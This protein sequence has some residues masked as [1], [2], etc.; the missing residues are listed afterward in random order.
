V[1]SVAYRSHPPLPGWI[2]ATLSLV[3]GWFVSAVAIL[4]IYIA[5]TL[6]GAISQPYAAW[7][8]G[9][10]NEWPYADNGP[11]SF[12]ANVAVVLIALV[13]ATVATSWRLRRKHA[14]VSDG[15]LAVVLLFA[16]WIPL[17]AA[18][19]TGGLVGFLVAL[20]LVRHWVARHEDHLAPKY[21]AVLVAVLGIVVVSYGLLHPLW[22]ASVDQNISFGKQRLAGIN[23]HNAA[24]VGVTIDRIEVPGGSGFPYGRPRPARLHLGPGDDGTIGLPIAPAVGGC[25]TDVLGIHAHYHVFGLALSETLPARIRLGRSC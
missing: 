25:G 14:H 10:L 5:A 15:R 11:W 4:L 24:R 17:R 19:P 22:T 13:L 1:G 20:V 21:A 12:F 18:G 7:H 9:A 16:G 3:V 23:V 8:A 6:V 2:D